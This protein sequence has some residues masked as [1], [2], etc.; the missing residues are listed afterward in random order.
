MKHFRSPAVACLLGLQF[1]VGMQVAAQAQFTYTYYPTDTTINS[2]VDTDFATVG[3][4]GGSYDDNFNANFT[5]PS[6]P[7]IQVVTG[8]NI[9]GEMDIFNT[10]I[11]DFTGGAAGAVVPTNSSTLNITGG[12]IGFALNVDHSVINMSGGLVDDLEGQG[13]QINVSGGTVGTLVANVNTDYLGNSLGSSIMNLTGGEITG[14]TSAFNDAILN[15][16][17][18]K[19]GSILRAAEGGTINIYGTGLTATLFNSSFG[20]G[21]S[22]YSLTGSL[23]DG[24][25]LNNTILRVRNDGITYGHSS[26]NL[27][28]VVPEP[29][30]YGLL[31]GSGLAGAG[32]LLRRR[33]NPRVTSVRSQCDSE[34]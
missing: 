9:L 29:G 10:S 4:A 31:L 16:Y 26:F 12:E 15:I 30:A 22:L 5:S 17:G 25:V 27:V 6:S 21:Y 28:N 19:L 11:V 33:R 7:T 23:E 3:Y 18:G 24:N 1:L 32:V 14:E 13:K 8:A 2:I 20:N 34:E